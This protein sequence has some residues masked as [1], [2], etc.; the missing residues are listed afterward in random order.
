MKS[1]LLSKLLQCISVDEIYQMLILNRRQP[2][3][4]QAVKIVNKIKSVIEK[5]INDEQKENK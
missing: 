3:K 5:I 1:E 2:E 4:I